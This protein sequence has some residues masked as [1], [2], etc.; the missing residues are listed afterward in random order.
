MKTNKRAKGIAAAFVAVVLMLCAAILVLPQSAKVFADETPTEVVISSDFEDGKTSPWTS[1]GYCTHS[2]AGESGGR[3]LQSDLISGNT[4]NRIQRRISVGQGD[5][6]MQEGKWY[7]ISLRAKADSTTPLYGVAYFNYAEGD[8]TGL[9]VISESYTNVGSDWT[10]ISFGF[11]FAV[12]SGNCNFL[13]RRPHMESATTHSVAAAGKTAISSVDLVLYTMADT[14]YFDDF[15]VETEMTEMKFDNYIV[16]SDF[17]DG[18][19]APWQG[20]SWASHSITTDSH[21]GEKALLSLK[22]ETASQNRA[23]TNLTVTP[24][25]NT[26]TQGIWHTLR[27]AA[28]AEKTAHFE[29]AF[30]I[31]YGGGDKTIFL[32]SSEELTTAYAEFEAGISFERRVVGDSA[33]IYAVWQR[34]DMTSTI[35]DSFPMAAGAGDITSV[36]LIIYSTD[37]QILYL[38]D[39]SI[40]TKVSVSVAAGQVIREI[41]D[42]GTVTAASKPAIDAAQA[43]YDALSASEKAEVF[44]Y[45]LLTAAHRSYA[46]RDGIVPGTFDDSDVVLRFA[47]LSDTHN[48]N[49]E[50]ALQK[51]ST[52]GGKSLDACVVAGDI[53][54][55]VEYQGLTHEIPQVKKC[56]EDNLPA[57]V[58]IFLALG[59]HDSSAGSNAT[60]FYDGLGE[61]FYGAVLDKAY[62]RT[63]ANAHAVIG[64]Y[65]FIAIETD[66]GKEIVPAATVQYLS[67]TLE[68]ITSDPSYHGEYIFLV[69]HVSMAN[70]VAGC[71]PIDTLTP[72]LANYP[73]VIALTGHSHHT[74]YDELNIMQTDYTTVCLGSVS[75]TPFEERTYLESLQ[76]GL[77]EGSYDL[78]VGSIVEVDGSGNVK[79]TRIDFAKDAEIAQPWILSAPKA[80]KTHLL[81][82]PQERKTTLASAP[83]FGS[84]AKIDA[85]FSSAKSVKITFDTATDDDYV[86]YYRI[87]LY[88]DGATIPYKTVNTLSGFWQ[89]PRLSDM[90]G[91]K[92]V[93]IDGLKNL[94]ASVKITAYD[95][96]GAHSA[97]VTAA[98]HKSVNDTVVTVDALNIN[99]AAMTYAADTKYEVATDSAFEHKIANSGSLSEYVGVTLYVREKE[100][101]F[102]AASEAASFTV[103][104]YTVTFPSSDAYTLYK[105]S[106]A[107]SYFVGARCEFSIALADGYKGSTVTVKAN[108]VALECDDDGIYGFTVTENTEIT[109]EVTAGGTSSG[110]K[111]DNK[112]GSDDGKKDDGK[113]GCGCG[114]LLT[115]ESVPTAIILLVAA[116]AV[117]AVSLKK[118]KSAR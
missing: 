70:T 18:N 58:S 4:Q 27:F 110:D 72:L 92:T 100:N 17:E 19:T 1:N 10:N 53:T 41:M 114:S 21:G 52:W 67:D 12:E 77:I 32:A 84:D 45:A 42:I 96:A 23:Q 40:T 71:S 3:Y 54:E 14:W 82:Y 33:S 47:A 22:G 11:S 50:K 2:V 15:K 78:S 35:S 81:A 95:S 80:D 115:W 116:L 25:G 31:N 29:I 38:D 57:S 85:S 39:I 30:T 83:T 34:T 105:G 99:N 103:N 49:V 37:A 106:S 24:A 28:K 6:F 16:S 48:H 101:E 59:N 26:L 13:F 108:G 44:N 55:A 104:H 97:T 56:F 65:H 111:D 86:E 93:E 88:D 109:V 87:E 5:G 46:L 60:T 75:Y 66:Y 107:D 94:P 20:G 91:E 74:L 117:L 113:S 118:R 63:T 90:P 36:D 64:G 61:R 79:I 8:S 43:A 112:G 68:S 76:H 98:A 62:T 51:V 9:F 102:R 7:D 69:S 89:Y 73:Q